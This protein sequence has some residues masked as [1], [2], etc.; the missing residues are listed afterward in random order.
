MTL[1]THLASSFLFVKAT[2][3]DRVELMVCVGIGSLFPDMIEM[4]LAG[5]K[6]GQKNWNAFWQI[7]RKFMHWWVLYVIVYIIGY[8]FMDPLI[9]VYIAYFL[10]GCLL[11]LAFDFFNPMGIPFLT[12]AGKRVKLGLV[13]TGSYKEFFVFTL[14]I[15]GLFI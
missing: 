1:L 15:L 4:F 14:L 6:N 8:I 9:F 11:H 10:Y 12:P 13:K 2:G 5:R 7:H 3:I